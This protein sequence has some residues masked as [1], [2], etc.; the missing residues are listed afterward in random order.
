[1]TVKLNRNQFAVEGPAIIATLLSHL[2]I[3]P[4]PRRR[5]TFVVAMRRLAADTGVADDYERIISRHRRTASFPSSICRS[6]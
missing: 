5:R 1:M 6:T 3:D 2:D 4:R